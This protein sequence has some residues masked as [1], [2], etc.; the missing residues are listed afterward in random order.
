MST[1]QDGPLRKFLKAV[2]HDHALLDKWWAGGAD[3]VGGDSKVA[4]LW[5]AL[6]DT[7]KALLRDGDLCGIQ[8]A[9]DDEGVAIGED[10]SANLGKNWALVR[11]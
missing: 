1:Q 9:L 5:A 2:G 10:P 3:A 6:S 11:V 8:K 7:D 4:R